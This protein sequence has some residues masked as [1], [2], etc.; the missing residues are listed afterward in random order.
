[1]TIEASADT[2]EGPVSSGGLIAHYQLVSRL[3][4]G[5]MGVVYRAMDTK[6]GREV[7]LKVLHPRVADDADRRRRFVREGRLAAHLTHPC[8]ATV[9]DVGEADDRVYIAMELV[10][11]DKLADL[12]S[13]E[14]PMHWTDALQIVHEVVRGLHK[15]HEMGVIHRDLKPDNLIVG[16]EGIVKILDFGVAKRLENFDVEFSDIKTQHG[17]LVGTPAYMSP[18]QAAGKEVDARSDIFSVGVV[19]YELVTGKRPFEGETWQEVI[20]AINRDAVKAASSLVPDMPAEVDMIISRCLAKGVEDRYP[21]CKELLDD[22]SAL[23][24][25]SA[26]GTIPPGSSMAGILSSASRVSIT[27]DALARQRIPTTTTIAPPTKGRTAALVGV[28][29]LV[30]I[31]VGIAVMQLYA[32]PPAQAVVTPAETAEP[33]ATQTASVQP[34]APEPSV[35]AP[36]VAP[37]ATASAAPAPKVIPRPRPTPK[38]VAPPVA[39]K[40]NPVLGF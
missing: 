6:L 22:L 28:A 17:S 15:A 36:P 13:P 12:V 10:E 19:M 1:M 23:V 35:A 20:I 29:A 33:T 18:E 2:D 8:I 5:G 16:E 3:G 26:T 31:G 27:G 11:G 14:R 34:P 38:T 32:K 4:E 39:P 24:V 25:V 30:T 21:S 9:F 40:S 7:A 37:T